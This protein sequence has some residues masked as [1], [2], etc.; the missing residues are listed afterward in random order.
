MTHQFADIDIDEIYSGYVSWSS[1]DVLCIN[2]S[3]PTQSTYYT[4]EDL[5]KML[6]ILDGKEEGVRRL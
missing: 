1:T 2:Y 6:D 5:I 3:G 4:R